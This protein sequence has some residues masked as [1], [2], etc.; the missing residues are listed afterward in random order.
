MADV[1]IARARA[2]MA[3]A[4]LDGLVVVKP[5]NVQYVSGVHPGPASWLWRRAGPAMVLLPA[6][7]A[8]A[9]AAVIPDTQEVAFRQGSD[10][11][12]LRTHP[13]WIEID[14]VSGLLADDRPIEDVIRVAAQRRPK[15][16]DRPGTYDLDR[17]L[18]L[19]SDAVRE[20]GLEHSRLG[21]E[22]DFIAANDLRAVRDRLPHARFVDSTRVFAELRAIKNAREIAALRLGAELTEAG[23]RNAVAHLAPGMPAAGVALAYRA[24]VI[25]AARERGVASLEAT[26]DIIS[27]G[28]QPWGRGMTTAQVEDGA[29]L[30]FDVGCTVAGLEADVGRTFV[31][32]R[33]REY[34]RRIQARRAD[35]RGFSC[36]AG[37][38]ARGRV[39]DLHA[40]PLRP[41]PRL[42]LRPRGVAVHRGR[43]ALRA[44][45]GHGL[46]AGDAVL[47][48]RHRRLHHRGPDLH[49]APGPREYEH[50][51]ARPCR[52]ALRRREMR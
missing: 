48:R 39:P 37:G 11:R 9:P 51:A 38:N 25:E 29:L 44:G 7:D 28:P 49:H 13:L 45:A 47:Y 17:C 32:G 23:L 14:D 22:L 15:P 18:R 36:R 52:G 10:I 34:Q 1:D 40:R 19:L 21:I 26:W 31:F 27:V 35:L 5:E 42:G 8:L 16:A 41:Q 6:D 24:G 30:K 50:A 3:A 4:G 2:L 43:R 12:D 46:R 20:R 33:A